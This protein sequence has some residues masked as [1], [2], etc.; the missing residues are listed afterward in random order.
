[1]NEQIMNADNLHNMAIKGL[2]PTASNL[3]LWGDE[4]E[5]DIGLSQ[6]GN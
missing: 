3:P 4:D 1:M 5:K 6:Y 2:W